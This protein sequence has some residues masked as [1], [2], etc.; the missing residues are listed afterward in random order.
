MYNK[1]LLLEYVQCG[2]ESHDNF[3]FIL[4]LFAR[5]KHGILLFGVL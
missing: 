2:S 1:H 3:L 5:K 4:L